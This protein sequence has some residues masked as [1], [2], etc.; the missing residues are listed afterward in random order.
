MG[1]CC[2]LE[3]PSLKLLYF[4]GYI[5][6]L[7]LRE[8]LKE[9]IDLIFKDKKVEYFELRIFYT[10]GDLFCGFFAL[11]VK[12]RTKNKKNHII[13]NNYD[14]IQ[15]P[16]KTSSN[17]IDL[18][19]KNPLIYNNN[20]SGLKYVKLKR[21]IY[22]SIFDT[23]AQSCYLIFSLI[24]T[25]E[26]YNMPYHKTNLTLVFDIIIRFIL[27]KICLDS[28]LYPHYCLSISISIFSF[29]I[30]SI[31]DIYFII[32]IG[33]YHHWIFLLQNGLGIILY[34]LED[35]EGKIGLKYELLNPY[36]LLFYKGII[37]SIILAIISLVLIILQKYYS[38]TGLFDN[39][40][41]RFNFLSFIILF[42]YII[43]NMLTNICI[44]KII[45]LYTIQHLTIIKG[46]S[47]F[48]FYINDLI[49]QKLYNNEDNKL[50][51]F[52]YF[53]DITGYFLMLFGTLIHNEIIIF[54]C[55][56]FS[57]YTQKELK[58]REENELNNIGE[59][60]SSFGISK[61]ESGETM[62][63]FGSSFRS[64]EAI[65]YSEMPI[66]SISEESVEF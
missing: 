11:I 62:Q 57:K 13:Q 39:E 15:K 4:I 65:R 14:K 42:S 10:I 58:E 5:I 24:Y 27:N 55:F 35:V 2:S 41:Y 47:S 19:K 66:N 63:T 16:K 49:R 46:G 61:K 3:P 29:I 31:S 40:K 25:G 37:Q 64:K 22:L 26:E 7:F 45:E 38:F 34:S 53:T 28:E 50:T 54:N 33:D 51:H 6:F 1:F 60:N 20:E 9:R 12:K 48:T 44:W 18:S 8:I 52:F 30:L 21:V 59:I 32:T 17:K 23:L 36:N 43:N 56:N